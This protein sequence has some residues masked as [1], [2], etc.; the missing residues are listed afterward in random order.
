MF[1]YESDF[2]LPSGIR[3]SLYQHVP[4]RMVSVANNLRRSLLTREVG[5]A[6][7]HL[8]VSDKFLSKTNAF[9]QATT[10]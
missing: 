10:C 6:F 2:Q 4:N 9:A 1:I 5:K 8:C 3:I 7:N